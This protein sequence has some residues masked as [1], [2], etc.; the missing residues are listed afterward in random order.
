MSHLIDLEQCLG[1]GACVDSCS[2]SSIVQEGD[3]YK[4]NS[5]S[6]TDCHECASACPVECISG[7]K[8]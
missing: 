1:C 3:K 2:S 6:C 5:D 4:I 8:K 7:E